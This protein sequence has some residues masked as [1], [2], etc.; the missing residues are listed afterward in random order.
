M[1]NRNGLKSALVARIYG[2]AGVQQFGNV[3]LPEITIFAQIAQTLKIHGVTS[4]IVHIDT[5]DSTVN[6]HYN[7]VY[8]T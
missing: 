8:R 2:L 6:F 5:I 3:L 7:V 4:V 1:R